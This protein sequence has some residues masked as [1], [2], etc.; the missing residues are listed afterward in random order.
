M[1]KVCV[2]RELSKSAEVYTIIE[3]FAICRKTVGNYVITL[4][5]ICTEICFRQNRIVFSKI[6]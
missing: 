6:R 1:Q 3:Q 4:S 5:S 2:P